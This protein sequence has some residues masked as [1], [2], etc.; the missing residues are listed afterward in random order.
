MSLVDDLSTLVDANDEEIDE[1]EA[2]NEA[3]ELAFGKHLQSPAIRSGNVMLSVPLHKLITLLPLQSHKLQRLCDMSVN[4]A[5]GS[6]MMIS[7]VCLDV[8]KINFDR[9]T[10]KYRI[11]YLNDEHTIK[12]GSTINEFSCLCNYLSPKNGGMGLMPCTS[13]GVEILGPCRVEFR[14]DMYNTTRNDVEGVINIFGTVTTLHDHDSVDVDERPRFHSANAVNLEKTDSSLALLDLTKKR[15]LSVDEV[16][17]EKQLSLDHQPSKCDSS[18]NGGI[19]LTK[20]ERKDLARE[21]A[22]Q[23][24][25]T[26]LASRTNDGINS[27]TLDDGPAKKKSKKKKKGMT[28]E[29]EDQKSKSQTRERRLDGGLIVSDILLGTGP[30]VKPGKRISLHYTGSLRSTGKVFD[31]NS[32]KQHPLVFRQGTGEV[33]RG[34][35]SYHTFLRSDQSTICYNSIFSYSFLFRIG[36]W[37]GWNEGRW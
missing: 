29:F 11:V 34:K 13:I 7:S 9:T 21:K 31:K 24:E 37:V 30:E 17:T 22:K 1:E 6:K 4:I 5:K 2:F 8:Q 36:A 18:I 16:S 33:I 35:L 32:S 27:I 12:S 19:L 20:K 14:A 3:D 23:L 26:L 25:E 28:T 10:L 15:K